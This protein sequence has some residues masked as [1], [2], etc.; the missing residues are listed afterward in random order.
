MGHGDLQKT[1]LWCVSVSLKTNNNKEVKVLEIHFKEP[2]ILQLNEKS[3]KPLLKSNEHKMCM[4]MQSGTRRFA[5][6]R[7]VV[8]V[9]TLNNEITIKTSKCYKYIL[10][11]QTC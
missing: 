6:D 8:L 2:D 7:F 9:T 3:T 10:R 1:D 4:M 5:K 11:S